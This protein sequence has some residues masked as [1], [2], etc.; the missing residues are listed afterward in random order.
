[1]RLIATTLRQGD[2][3]HSGT[4]RMENFG[5]NSS[6]YP[7]PSLRVLWERWCNVM[8]MALSYRYCNDMIHLLGC[9][10]VTETSF[11]RYGGIIELLALRSFYLVVNVSS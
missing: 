11:G 10:S 7:E 8:S 6:Y 9:I 5:G 3:R 2:D 1:M 4:R